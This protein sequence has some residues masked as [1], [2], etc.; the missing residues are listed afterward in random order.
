M[1]EAMQV[2]AVEAGGPL[3]AGAVLEAVRRVRQ[4]EVV[5]VEGGPHLM[6]DFFSEKLLDELFLTLS[7]QVA[8]RDSRSERPGFVSGTT[9]AP[10]RPVWGRLES[11]RRAESHLFLRYAF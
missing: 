1:P 3:S 9:F 11:L 7:P 5:L 2:E 4:V 10:E 8:G 6:G